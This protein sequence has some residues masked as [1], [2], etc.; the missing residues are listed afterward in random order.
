[1]SYR[2]KVGAGAEKMEGGGERGEKETLAH[3]PHDSGKHPLIFH[4]SVDF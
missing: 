4:S 1:M 2:E 3:K